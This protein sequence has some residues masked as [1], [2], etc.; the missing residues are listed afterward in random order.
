MNKT[1]GL[2]RWFS[3]KKFA[4][5]AREAGDAGL[6]PGS[7]RSPEG[8]HGNPLQYSWPENPHGQRSLV[9]YSPKGRKE[10]DTTEQRSTSTQNKTYGCIYLIKKLT[11]LYLFPFQFMLES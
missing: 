11:V 2:P 10:S 4:C 9:G 1:Q 3:S 6:I 5:N 8:G 7:G